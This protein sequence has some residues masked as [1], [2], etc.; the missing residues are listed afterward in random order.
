[1]NRNHSGTSTTRIDVHVHLAGTGTGGS[2]CYVSPEFRRSPVFLGLRLLWGI[3]SESLDTDCDQRWAERLAELVRSSQLDHAVALG[4]DGVYDEHGRLDPRRSQLI[5]PPS[6]VFQVC[7]RFPE[8]LPGPSINPHRH[9]ALERLEE[10]V[11]AGA[12]LIKWLPLS[13]GVNPASPRISEFYEVLARAGIPILVHMG[14]ERTFRT[15]SPELNDVRLLTAPLEAGV[16]VICAHSATRILFSRE[17]DQLPV[18]RGMLA[19]YPHLWLDNS[20]MANPGRFA[21]LPRLARDPA[22]HERTLYGS[23]F[24]VPANSLY[25]LPKLGL[26]TVLRLERERNLIDRDVETKRALGYPDDTLLRAAGVLPN[27]ERWTSRS[28]AAGDRQTPTLQ[29][30]SES[31]PPAR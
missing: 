2:G 6:W 13:Q 28:D 5:V 16:P 20:G 3:S 7:E 29:P 18:L 26:R 9:D 11:A 31:S 19:D 12:V 27:L 24:P 25:F 8:L 30:I 4:F 17:Q 23:D 1:M 10:C 15:L 14:G 22:F 21:H